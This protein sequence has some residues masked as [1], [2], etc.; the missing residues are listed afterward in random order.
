MIQPQLLLL[1]LFSIADISHG[2]IL[3]DD[4]V[5]QMIRE[6]M[7]AMAPS[8]VCGRRTAVKGRRSRT[9]NRFLLKSGRFHHHRI[10]GGQNADK[11]EW[12]WLAAIMF[13]NRKMPFCGGA[14][15][16]DTHVITAAHCVDKYRK[17][18][19]RVRVGEYSF[20]HDGETEDETFNVTSMKIHKGWNPENDDNDIAILKLDGSATR[21]ASVSPICLPSAQE[22]WTDTKAHV[23]G[24]GHT[25]WL[26]MKG[27]P[28]LQEAEVHIWNNKDC[29][30]NYGELD[31]SVTEKMLCANGL[32]RKID[33][34]QGDSGGPLNCFNIKT[35]R[36]ELC[37]IVSFGAEC[38]SLRYPGVYTRITK[39]LSWIDNVIKN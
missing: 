2:G 12:P 10:V 28:I 9:H 36:W 24:W 31:K 14:I 7:G 15:I 6:A 8:K 20:E 19:L 21:S 29:A 1:L 30:K 33:S 32:T 22:Q 26:A 3:D 18:Q 39:Y 37:G 11:Y 34:C 27:S 5:L 23:I 16:S 17:H 38:A 13:Q 35:R 4:E 25:T